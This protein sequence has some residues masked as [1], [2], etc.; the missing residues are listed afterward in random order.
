MAKF[1]PLSR[2]QHGQKNWQRP[3]TYSFAARDAVVPIVGQ[4]LATAAA[5]L[6]VGFIK[7]GENY[8]L[9]ALLSFRPG[10]NLFT[11]PDGRWVGTYIPALFRAYPFRL[12]RQEGGDN[13]VLCV[14]EDSEYITDD[15][16]SELFFDETG[17]SSAS[18]NQVADFLQQLER[19]RIST[20]LAVKALSSAG[21]IAP[22]EIR[23]RQGEREVPVSG[24]F[25]TDESQLNALDD[26]AFLALRKAN[27]LA[28]AYA[29]IISMSRLEV[30]GRLVEH[31]KKV[32]KA[33]GQD[34]PPLSFDEGIID[35][36]KFI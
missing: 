25:R 6:P 22:W 21:V 26:K 18:V 7:Q 32:A 28:I 24:F 3:E 23:V 2:Q 9:A 20:D 8:H 27:A 16:G 5:N 35:F 31:H 17:K 1:V 12:I 13:M 15:H 14:D 10:Q 19:S 29:Q 11:G 33:G 30:L 34:E 36:S 4:E